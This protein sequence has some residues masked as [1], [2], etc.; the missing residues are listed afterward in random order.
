MAFTDFKSADQVQRAYQIK[1]VEA[2]FLRINP[3]T[4]SKNFIEEYEFSKANFDIFA[5][6]ASRC[7][8]VIYPLLR[9]VC[10]KFVRDYSLWSHKPIT[11]DSKLSGT[12]DY[13]IAKRSELGKNVLEYPL[14]LITEAK[15]NNFIQGWGQ[16]LAELV[17][18]QILNNNTEN[19]VY[20]C[21]TDAEFWQFGK[22]EGR[23]FTRNQ[24]S[25]NIDDLEKV[26]GALHEIVELSINSM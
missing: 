4:P 22:L 3:V 2:D 19:A 5:S 7:E 9:D 17:A 23:L 25:V 14:V 18:A 16:C 24:A 21:V 20:G 26:A 6:E 10:K 12:P 13:I 15:Q 1:Y 11:A 8:N